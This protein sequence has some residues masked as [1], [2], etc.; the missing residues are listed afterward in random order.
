MKKMAVGISEKYMRL[1]FKLSSR[2]SDGLIFIELIGRAYFE[3]NKR[4]WP[5]RI[6]HFW[7]SVERNTLLLLDE[8]SLRLELFGLWSKKVFS[9]LTQNGRLNL[10]ALFNRH[11][12]KLSAILGLL[13][14]HGKIVSPATFSFSSVATTATMAFKSIR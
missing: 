7:I 6:S 9:K 14:S 13:K 2:T 12:S 3:N 5:M 10:D 1:V 8:N 4:E 11:W